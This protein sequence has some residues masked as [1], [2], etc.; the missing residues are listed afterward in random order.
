M[1]TL[2]FETV[3][4]TGIITL[5]KS[6]TECMVKYTN[7]SFLRIVIFPT[8]AAHQRARVP[9][10]DC[11]LFN[12]AA[13]LSLKHIVNTGIKPQPVLYVSRLS[14]FTVNVPSPSTKPDT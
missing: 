9:K 14:T 4:I 12:K 5:T 10:K 8:R 1:D 6:L 3:E 7:P 13:S 11:I 2:V